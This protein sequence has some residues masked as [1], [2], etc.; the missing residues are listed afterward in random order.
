MSIRRIAILL[1]REVVR[2]PK[3]F[4]FIF[5]IIV[6]VVLSLLVNLIFGAYFVAKPKLGV[7]DLGSSQFVAKAQEVESIRLEE[8]TSVEAMR[9]AVARG[10]LD[11]GLV[12][13][14]GL[15]TALLQGS[16]I[17]LTGY[18]WGESLMKDR[19]VLG[20]TVIGLLRD[21]VGQEP[22][23]EIVTA[24]V[25]DAV[26]VPW[27]DRLLP[28]IVMITILVGGMM[29]PATSL[30]DE[31]QKR[32]LRALVTTPTTVNDVLAAKGL[33]GVILSLAMG[34][35]ILLL[36]QAFGTHPLLL[37]LLTALGAV[38]AAGFGV[39]LGA[40]VKDI[41]TLFATIKGLGILLYAPALVYLFPEIP[42]WIGRI[43]PTYYMIAPIIEVTQRGAGW[44][45][46]ALEVAILLGL[47]VLLMVI[48]GI[49][50]R[51]MQTREAG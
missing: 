6:P 11:L 22:P 37:V 42:Q 24:S 28:F 26:S 31:K 12:L 2:G 5:A 35:L 29:I 46:I 44:Q 9:S 21:M 14:D 4:L 48:I 10:A 30:V 43:F 47:I 34:V 7:A 33:L 23:V 15:D 13:P 50:G 32:T 41:D 45:D 16:A 1:E 3:N 19:A 8:Y 20:T 17:Q 25:G 38:M 49:A 18:I 39:L 51:R 27:E 40:L 36:N